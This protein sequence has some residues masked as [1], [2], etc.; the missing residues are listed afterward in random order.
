MGFFEKIKQG[1]KKTKDS[2]GAMLSGIF[3]GRRVDEA[4]ME[5]IPLL[6]PKKKGEVQTK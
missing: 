5:L 2:I 6:A 1:L 4:L 3:F